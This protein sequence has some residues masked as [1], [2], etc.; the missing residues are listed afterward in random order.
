MRILNVSKMRLELEYRPQQWIIGLGVACAVLAI[1]LLKALFGGEFGGAGIASV[2]L[3]AI[4]WLWL[5]R[6]F[7]TVRL[8][9]DRDAGTLRIATVSLFGERF[10]ERDLTDLTGAEVETRFNESHSSAEPSLVLRFGSERHRMNLF[11]PDPAD[12]LQAAESINAWLAQ[13]SA[14]LLQPGDPQT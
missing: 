8:T 5:T 1:A 2:M 4:G 9:A 13:S 11:K 6:I 14:P 12:L 10:R 7:Q 3:A